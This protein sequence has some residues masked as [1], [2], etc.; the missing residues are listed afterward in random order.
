MELDK[1]DI[2]IREKIIIL[3]FRQQLRSIVV[4]DLNF[5]YACFKKF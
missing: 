1:V 2:L 3:I 4:L 5:L